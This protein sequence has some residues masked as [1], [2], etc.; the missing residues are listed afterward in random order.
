M[1]SHWNPSVSWR[2]WPA[3]PCCWAQPWLRRRTDRPAPRVAAPHRAK[4]PR[5]RQP[6]RRHEPRAARTPPRGP[7]DARRHRVRRREVPR[8]VAPRVRRLEDRAARR[9]SLHARSRRQVARVVAVP[10]GPPAGCR[11]RPRPPVS[12]V[13]QPEPFAPRRLPRAAGLLVVL[14][15]VSVDRPL[16]TPEALQAS[17]FRLRT[18]NAT[19]ATPAPQDQPLRSHRL[20][21]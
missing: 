10:H 11:F 18:Q 3:W 5:L 20:V 9:L 8:P 13:V 1:S 4:P 17:A 14:R 16:P 12:P 15:P 7:R 19:S 6:L 2:T 21:R